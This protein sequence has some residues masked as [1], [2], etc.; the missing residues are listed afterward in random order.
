MNKLNSQQVPF[1]FFCR[2]KEA[3]KQ[4]KRKGK[5][6]FRLERSIDKCTKIREAAKRSLRGKRRSTLNFAAKQIK[7]MGKSP[8]R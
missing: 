1:P 6:P 7:R 2:C 3:A 8:F 4:I 5:L